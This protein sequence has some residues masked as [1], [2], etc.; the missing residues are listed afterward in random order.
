VTIVSGAHSSPV[1]RE[2]ADALAAMIPGAEL[3][4]LDSGHFAHL[5]Q[6]SEVAAAIRGGGV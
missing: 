6:P 4:T 1:R 5:E 2:A 3:R